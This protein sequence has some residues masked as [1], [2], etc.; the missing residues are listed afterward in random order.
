MHRLRP[1]APRDSF[2]VLLGLAALCALAGCSH[3][4]YTRGVQN[5]T[6]R[7][8]ERLPYPEAYYR[9]A[10]Y[11]TNEIV[12]AD[13]T[14]IVGA[15]LGTQLE[16]TGNAFEA[17]RK[18][19]EE[20]KRTAEYSYRVHRPDEYDGAAI[21]IYYRWGDTDGTGLQQLSLET[22]VNA[23]INGLHEA[24]YTSSFGEGGLHMGGQESLYDDWLS[25]SIL[26]RIG[27]I[28]Y[29]LKPGPSADRQLQDR[30]KR[31]AE[32]WGF[33]VPSHFGLMIDPEWLYGFGLR[34]W[35]GADLVG[36]LFTRDRGSWT[37]KFDY[38]AE[39]SWGIIVGDFGFS[40]LAGY[41]HYNFSWGEFWTE[42]DQFYGS[43]AIDV[44]I[45]SLF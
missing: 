17:M 22:P 6:S 11:D 9:D 42:Y 43:F 37:D 28:S 45:V 18:A 44:D 20:G 25:W 36:W 32:A 19:E 24:P 2:A 31:D 35:G 16:G 38:G 7:G 33:R 4:S 39:A 14:G 3:V 30:A 8:L 5:Q 1:R 29:D 12:L 26:V 40:L 21:G 23:E 10:T 41:G 13:R 15:A 34:A 27:M